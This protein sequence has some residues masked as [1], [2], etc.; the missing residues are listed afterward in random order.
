[1]MRNQ[2]KKLRQFLIP[3]QKILLVLLTMTI[4]IFEIKIKN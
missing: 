4:A 1:M 3:L 2:K